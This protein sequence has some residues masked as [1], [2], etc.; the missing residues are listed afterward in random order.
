VREL[1][2]STDDSSAA[3]KAQ[4]EQLNALAAKTNLLLQGLRE[5]VEGSQAAQKTAISD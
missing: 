3:F 2:R 4:L 5:I 1:Q